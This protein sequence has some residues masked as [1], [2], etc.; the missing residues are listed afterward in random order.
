[1]TDLEFKVCAKVCAGKNGR[2][3]VARKLLKNMVPATRFE[4]VTPR[5]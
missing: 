5:V 4:L 1:M 3:S 2:L